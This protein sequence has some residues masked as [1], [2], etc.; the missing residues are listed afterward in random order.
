[1]EDNFSKIYIEAYYNTIIFS[2][3][4]HKVKNIRMGYSAFGY[5]SK[6]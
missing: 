4:V 1:M 3:D 2:L 5:L 6:G